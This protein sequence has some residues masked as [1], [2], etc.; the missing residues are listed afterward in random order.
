MYDLRRLA[1]KGTDLEQAQSTTVRVKL[2][3]S[4]H[5]PMSSA[6]CLDSNGRRLF[7]KGS[8]PTGIRESSADSVAYLTPQLPPIPAFAN[9][10]LRPQ[11]P[12]CSAFKHLPAIR[13]PRTT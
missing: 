7:L 12:H 10:H 11:R 13:V 5:L 3:K 4:D 9:H 6:P 2:L 8:L 1:L